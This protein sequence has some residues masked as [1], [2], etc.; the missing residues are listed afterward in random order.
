MNELD[1]LLAKADELALLGERIS[2][3]FALELAVVWRDVE[4]E[5]S[6]LVARSRQQNVE[7][8]VSLRL[9]V[10]DILHDSG[11]D[12]LVAASA[13]VGMDRIIGAVLGERT[14]E[15]ID[16][17]K[18]NAQLTI[19][20][21]QRIAAEDLLAHGD[22][23]STDLWR[24][25][26]QH[27]FTHKPVREIVDALAAVLEDGDRFVRTLFDTQVSIF[28]RQIEAASTEALGPSQPFLYAGPIDD[29]TRDF[30]LERIGKVFTRAEIDDMDN[31]QIANVFV[32]GGGYNCRHSFLA[33]ESRELRA[34][35]G[36]GQR[37]P[38]LMDDIARIEARK[39][40]K[41]ARRKA[42]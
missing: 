3:R 42:A 22:R 8:I 39:A 40:A 30:C 32:T 4:R 28:G 14:Q 18:G 20:A 23:V 7:R 26:A 24:A 27:A 11:Y 15:D 36:T 16:G 25:L 9:R 37:V 29:R 2:M 13:N 41:A 35:V 10:R 6:V 38:E 33:V 31:E 17:F 34:L 1:R 12:A 5:L 19:H 21:L